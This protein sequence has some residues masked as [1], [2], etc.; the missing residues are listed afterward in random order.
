LPAMRGGDAGIGVNSGMDIHASSAT[1]AVAS[2]RR[3]DT[4]RKIKAQAVEARR[5]VRGRI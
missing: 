2:V 1:I 3:S 4:N 5:A